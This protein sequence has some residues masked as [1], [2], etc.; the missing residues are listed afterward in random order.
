M[1]KKELRDE[2]KQLEELKK[3]AG[4]K[5][6][7]IMPNKKARYDE[8]KK[9]KDSASEERKKIIDYMETE[10]YKLL[11][12]KYGEIKFENKPTGITL[13]ESMTYLLK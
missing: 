8:L 13:K 5:F 12:S 10:L 7:T 4:K 3:R 6:A 2:F 11:K 9:M 1:L